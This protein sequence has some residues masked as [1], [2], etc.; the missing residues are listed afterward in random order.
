M[1][2]STPPLH[3]YPTGI[4]S[5]QIHNITGLEFEKINRY[6]ARG[7]EGEDI[8]EGA[9]D[10]PS[11]YA[12]VI[13]NHQTIFKTRTKPKSAKPFFNAGTE[14]LIRDW[15]TT[16]AMVSVRDSRTHENNPLL[17]LVYLPLGKVFKDRSQVIDN[18]P[19][20]GGIAYGRIR[21]SMVFRSLQL[22]LPRELLGWDTYATLEI[23]SAIVSQNLQH[24]LQGL[25]LK[26]RAGVNR[27]KMYTTKAKMDG[28]AHWTGKHGRPVRLAVRKRYCTSLVVE[29]RKNSLGS[30]K[31]PAFAILWLKDIPD[32]EDRTVSVPVWRGDSEKLKRAESNCLTD[33]MGERAGSIEVPLKLYR[34]LGAYHQSLASRSPNLQDVFEVL[35][36]ASDNQEIQMAMGDDED[37]SSSD[38]DSS[39]DEGKG[40]KHAAD[41]LLKKISP[42]SKSS[43]GAEANEDDSAQHSGPID[44]I[45]DYKKHSK[46]LH[47]RHR[48]LMQWKVARTGNYV[49]TK[50]EHGKDHLLD[51]FQHHE[52]QP[53]I[54]TEV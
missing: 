44:D 41:G 24:D 23:T 53:G 50:I 36:T 32:G 26:L 8:A 7:D 52:R 48:G 47:R 5:I 6:Q 34:G 21:V 9:G 43:D 35:S 3:D 38:S 33:E 18:Y 15:H 40:P 16:E 46:Q 1:I 39:E 42:N 22:Q 51:S 2:T 14:R 31:T 10:L 13:L 17:G 20:V 37:S 11:S 28:E 19:L 25:R 45:R 30:D 4:L 54:E 27:G 29:F 49:K 12:T